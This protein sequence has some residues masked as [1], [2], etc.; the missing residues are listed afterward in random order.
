MSQDTLSLYS[1]HL[2]KYGETEIK[3]AM[4]KLA[5]EPRREGETAF[6]DLATVDQAIRREIGATR[7][8]I[9]DCRVCG[10]MRMVVEYDAQGDRE[11]KDCECRKLWWKENGIDDKNRH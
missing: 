10:N 11:A 9:G 3:K 7:T 6:P 1:S 2:T 8:K 4:L 5:L